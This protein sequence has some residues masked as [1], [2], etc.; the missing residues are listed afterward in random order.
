MSYI[1][2]LITSAVICIY[3]LLVW[4]FHDTLYREETQKKVRKTWYGLCFLGYG[5][6]ISF[7]KVPITIGNGKYLFPPE[8][9]K[10]FVVFILFIGF[11]VIVDALILRTSRLGEFKIAGFSGKFYGEEARENLQDQMNNVDMLCEKI[12][13]EYEIVQD[14]ERYI[15]PLKDKLLD[16][17]DVD[18]IAELQ[19]FLKNYCIAQKT[20]IDIS[21]YDAQALEEI[22]GHYHLTN[23]KSKEL[24]RN[25]QDKCSTF[26]DKN[27]DTLNYGRDIL[28][29]P[30]IF[31][32]YDGTI[33]I[34]LQGKNNIVDHEQF[35]ILNLVKIFESNIFNILKQLELSED[36]FEDS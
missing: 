29:I 18:W 34:A 6:Y 22:K 30:V 20:V 32:Y 23:S 1:P 15:N 31:N 24:E 4:K 7:S 12:Q 8:I 13:A 11:A 9:T 27:S 10:L 21:I 2:L 3:S 17:Q 26:C 14:S 19:D 28:F 5:L 33:L 16:E 36:T 25:I 35:M